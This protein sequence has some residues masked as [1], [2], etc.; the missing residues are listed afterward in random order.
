MTW[1]IT[2]GNGMQTS[3]VVGVECFMKTVQFMKG[4]GMRINV[5]EEECCDYVRAF[6][7]VCVI[8]KPLP[9]RTSYLAGCEL[10]KSIA[11]VMKFDIL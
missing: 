10:L 5:M 4:N 7:T 3:G 2:K 9:D 11:V 6:K 1:S 8:C